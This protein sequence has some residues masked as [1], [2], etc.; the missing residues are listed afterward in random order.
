[1]HYDEVVD[2]LIT[3]LKEKFDQTCFKIYENLEPL[4]LKS[5]SYSLVMLYRNKILLTLCKINVQNI[6][7]PLN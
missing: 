4:L 1:M 3:S 6:L 7:N 2:S 5:V